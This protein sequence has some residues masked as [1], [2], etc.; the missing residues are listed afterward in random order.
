MNSI[1]FEKI[2][3]KALITLNKPPLNILSIVDLIELNQFI[4]KA[5]EDN[6][7]KL[8]ILK[9]NQKIF[10]AGIDITDH[11]LE[12][13][14]KMLNYFHEIFY[15]LI[16]LKIPVLSVI[17]GGC[18]GGGAELAL[19]CDF[20]IASEK[21]FFSHSEI[22]L[23]CFPPVSMVL[24]PYLIS[25]KKALELIMTGEKITAL[26]AFELGLI[27]S[28]CQENDLNKKVNEFTEKIIKNSGSVNSLI[29]KTFKQIHLNEL[30]DKLKQAEKIY[31]KELTKLKDYEEGINSFIEKRQP[32]WKN[33]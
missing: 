31:L 25:N 33:L 11:S 8:I 1:I 13:T 19:F 4:L 7:V 23:G 3:N 9:S 26:N 16:D 10:S 15:T 18:F 28:C 14:E 5:S 12:N 29:L 32:V 30:K 6:D 17:N 27:N 2:E 20:V 24:L 21:A 22:K